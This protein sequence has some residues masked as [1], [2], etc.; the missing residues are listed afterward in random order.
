MDLL[1]V[2]VNILK[3][4]AGGRIFTQVL[5]FKFISAGRIHHQNYQ[6]E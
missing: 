1:L 4:Y 3:K 5:Q 2:I 6:Q